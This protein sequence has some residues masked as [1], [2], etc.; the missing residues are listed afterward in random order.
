MKGNRPLTF[1]AYTMVFFIGTAP[2]LEKVISVL[3]GGLGNTAWR[4]GTVGVISGALTLPLLALALAVG[5]AL[6]LEHRR[7]MR[8]LAMLAGLGALLPVIVVPLFLLD[9]VQLRNALNED[10][11]LAFYVATAAAVFKMSAAVV[12]GSMTA[13]GSWRSTIRVAK[14]TGLARGD[15]LMG[16]KG[17]SRG[18]GR[19]PHEILRRPV[20]PIN[21]SV[22]SAADPGATAQPERS[23]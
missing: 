21:R 13:V 8:V 17:P 12:L 6:I 16:R 2:L 7:T 9:A 15:L 5:L 14:R 1:A 20:Q 23:S 19:G 4:Y 18:W 11:L 22:R 3:P 10:V